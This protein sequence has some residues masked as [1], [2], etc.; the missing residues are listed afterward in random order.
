MNQSEIDGRVRHARLYFS[1][2]FDTRLKRQAFTTEIKKSK[3]WK[4]KYRIQHLFCV[5][6]VN[7]WCELCD[8]DYRYRLLRFKKLTNF[9][10]GLN[11]KILVLCKKLYYSGTGRSHYH[12]TKFHACMKKYWYNTVILYSFNFSNNFLFPLC[13]DLDGTW[14][15]VSN[16]P[17]HFLRLRV[18]NDPTLLCCLENGSWQMPV[19]RYALDLQSRK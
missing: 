5:E 18:H 12:S 2:L 15:R 11:V 8:N 17:F 9:S 4:P 13:L 1:D 6:C 14:L 3:R 19:P 16:A 7:C 10:I